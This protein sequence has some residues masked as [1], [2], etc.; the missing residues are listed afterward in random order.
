MTARD[1][2]S[3]AVVVGLLAL[4]P[5]FVTA[6]TV[7]NFLV[8]TLVIALAAQGWNLLGGFGGQFSFG[9]A[10]FF[11][12]GAYATALLQAR[13]GVNAWAGFALAI[14]AGAAIGWLIGYLSFRSGL[15]GSYFALVT[16]AFAEVLRI[17]TNATG[18]TGGAAGLLLK[19]DA[20]PEN[21]QFASRAAFFW[22]ALALVAAA[23]VI[24]RAVERSRFGAQLVAVRENEAAAKALGVDVLAVKLK[25]ITLSAA[26][27]AAAGAF[28]T[29]YF[30][31]IDAT[32]AYG[33]WI[34][35]EALL[36]PIIGGLGTVFGPLLGAFTLHGLGELTKTFAGSV[37]GIDLVIFGALLIV[38]V[39]FAPDG[40]LGLLRRLGLRGRARGA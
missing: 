34:S 33:T 24:T 10:A 2:V 1:L 3:I 25:A 28:Y 11:G 22:I 35:V 13:L 5:L 26:I 39:A 40:L 30:L 31:Y 21:F 32:I 19:L 6:N 16:L 12:T 7:L 17:L 29:Q 8:F 18:F 38:A 36:A 4:I 23:L 9:H 27:T 15:R 20:R 37:P 14:A